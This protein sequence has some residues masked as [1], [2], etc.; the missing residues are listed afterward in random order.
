VGDAMFL[1]TFA[2]IDVELAAD[3]HET[4]NIR[5]TGL[6]QHFSGADSPTTAVCSDSRELII[7]QRREQL[8]GSVARRL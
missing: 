5:I 7:G 4:G 2:L 3:D 8:I 1:A 6:D